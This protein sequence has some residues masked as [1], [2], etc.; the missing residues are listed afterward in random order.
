[1]F[2]YPY[3]S[4]SMEWRL[5]RVVPA[6]AVTTHAKPHAQQQL[7]RD[8]EVDRAA[9]GQRCRPQSFGEVQRCYPLYSVPH[10]QYSCSWASV[11]ISL[12]GNLRNGLG[13]NTTM[14]KFFIFVPVKDSAIA[15]SCDEPLAAGRVGRTPRGGSTQSATPRGLDC[16]YRM[17]H[18]AR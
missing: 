13:I 6:A 5:R 8:L 11:T 4:T 9:M 18:L 12:S 15:A 17:P 14:K 7:V 1:M 3:T 16:G 10:T 2:W